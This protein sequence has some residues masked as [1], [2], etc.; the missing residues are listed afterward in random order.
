[1]EIEPITRKE[2][3]LAAAAGQDVSAP[4]PITREEM[5]LDAIAKKGGSGGGD[6][7]DAYTRSQTDALLSKK[8]NITDVDSKN[9]EQDEQISSKPSTADLQETL[10]LS[11][12]MACPNNAVIFDD[13]GNPSTMVFI[14]AFKLSDVLND[15]SEEL[16]GL[17]P[18]FIVNGQEIPGFWYSKYQN[19]IRNDRAC[20]LPAEDPQTNVSFENIL[21]KC[22]NKGT[23]WHLSTAAEWAAIALWCKKNNF[24][25]K[26]N[27]DNGKDISEEV[28]KAIP[29]AKDGNGKILRVATGTGPLSWSHDNTISGIWDLNGN[30]SEY[31]GGIR[32]VWGELQVLENNNSAD[33]NNEQSAI[34]DLWKAIDVATGNLV[35]PECKTTDISSNVKISGNTVRLDYVNNVWTFTNTINHLQSDYKSCAFVKVL[36][37]NTIS[38]ATKLLLRSLAVLPEEGAK[39]EEYGDYIYWH[40][41][42]SERCVTRGGAYNRGEY[43]GVFFAIGGYRTNKSEAIGFRSAYIPEL[44]LNAVKKAKS[45]SETGTGTPLKHSFQPTI[46]QDFEINNEEEL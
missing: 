37:D 5:F 24:L 22:E 27:N 43:C 18:A 9:A 3:Y 20:S 36:C 19:C 13:A 30:I 32:T 35:E 15:V 46:V 33:T 17:H 31:Q 34:S 40:N 8:A 44:S 38:V 6:S 12:K 23:G 7:N 21:I 28:Y 4:K 26:G 42:A 11:V 1:M 2:Q 41:N 10:D 25:P 16:D 29:T 39:E 45:A 14:P